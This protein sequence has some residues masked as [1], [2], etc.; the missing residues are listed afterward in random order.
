M[1]PILLAI[2]LAVSYFFAG[3]ITLSHYGISWDETLH[4]YRGQ[5]YLQYFL[6]GK[7]TYDNLPQINL[8]GTAGDPNKV[9]VP[10][11]S[12][13]QSDLYSGEYFLQND[14]GHPPVNGEIAA[15]LN[16]IFYQKLGILDDISSYHLF[17]ILA[18]TLL[19]FVVVLFAAQTLGI[20]GAIVAFLALAT[21]PL[22][23]AESHFNVK[24]PPE[25]AFFAATI[26]AFYASFKK[27]NA[28]WLT[29][30]FI[31]FALG[32]GT[33]FN[34]LFLPFI[35]L[36]YLLIRYRHFLLKPLKIFTSI[37]TKYLLTLLLGPII[38]AIIF[39]G[40]W[41][42]LWQNFPGNLLNIF[43]YYQEI[44]TGYRYQPESFFIFG[45]NTFPI[46]WIIFTT[47]PLVLFL[48]TVGLISLLVGKGKKLAGGAGVLWVLWFVV[49][50]L[51]V[52]MP[53]TAIY[54]GIRQV[55]EFLPAMS[56]IAALG[57][58]Q[59]IEYLK[60][61]IKGRLIVILQILVVLMFLWPIFVIVKM[62]PNENV[63]FNFLIGGLKGAK[64][65]KFPSWGNSFGN[66][67][68]QG[69]KWINENAEKNSKLSLIQGT[70]TNAPAIFLREDIDY[71]AGNW[72]GIERGR[73][74]LMELTFN[75][76]TRDFNYAWD[77]VENFL[78]PVYEIKI[79]GV[80]ILK[81]WKNDLQ[82]T[83]E[84]TR[85]NEVELAAPL[86]IKT[87]DNQIVLDLGKVALLSRLYLYFDPLPGCLTPKAAFIE[88][89][90]D[91]SVW[92]REKDP[93]PF[94]QIKQEENIGNGRIEY[95][96]A[97]K[98]VRYAK[99]VFES[100]KDCP[101]NYTSAKVLVLSAE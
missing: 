39:F 69:L 28:L 93:V 99:F 52:S 8:Q 65:Q 4:F 23:W 81:I 57:A 27:G 53:N 44:G 36:P 42:Y 11:R 22:F 92:I 62:H 10:R 72:S 94:R 3:F 35:I 38:V 49:P 40:T 24:D 20:F 73:E 5:A 96:I 68:F 60:K 91:G 33:K 19:V 70:S 58:W 47:P 37:P 79:E 32:L 88:I 7:Q 86:E 55:M 12:F 76:S 59:L 63:Y 85:K 74:Y 26:F 13:Y 18:S 34:I 45:F 31:F 2:I 95:F 15:F 14:S 83:K 87:F 77:Y 71:K 21:Y 97:G 98:E 25:A 17:N 9:M 80:P 84:L 67:Y 89:S 30:A 64:E 16:Y 78:S 50:I 1:K 56:L 54:G 90:K 46:K 82:H 101:L 29:A 75:D 100:P 51:R 48:F 41:P 43:G 61:F 66:A 6:T